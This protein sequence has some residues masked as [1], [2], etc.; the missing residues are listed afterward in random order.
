[1]VSNYVGRCHL[2]KKIV[3]LPVATALLHSGLSQVHGFQF[4]NSRMA[5]RQRVHIFQARNHRV[6]QQTQREER[7][8]MLSS[9]FFY[10]LVVA[11]LWV[12]SSSALDS[13]DE[14]SFETIETR[15][16]S[17]DGS[18]APADTIMFDDGSSARLILKTDGNDS[19][20]LPPFG[21]GFISPA[22]AGAGNHTAS[23]TYFFGVLMLGGLNTSVA[24]QQVWL[25]NRDKPIRENGTLKFT[26]EGG[27]VLQD[28]DGTSVWSSGPSGKS[29]VGIAL[30][31][32]GNLQLYDANSTVFWQSFDEPSDALLPGQL[33]YNE[34]RLVAGTSPNN[35]SSGGQYYVQM[36]SDGF[37]AFVRADAPLKYLNLGPG[38][39][40]R[41]LSTA[42]QMITN[43]KK[44]FVRKPY[45]KPCTYAN[46]CDRRRPDG[47]N[48]SHA[49]L[50]EPNNSSR[51][52]PPPTTYA[53][54]DGQYF[55]VTIGGTNAI[56]RI[57]PESAAT[58]S[59][60][61]LR[62][63]FD[64]HLRTYRWQKTNSSEEIYDLVTKQVDYCQHPD[65]C[66]DYGICNRGST[67]SC[68][69]ALINGS[70]YFRPS[71]GLGCSENVSL[72]CQSPLD[73][74]RLV[75]LGNLSYFS[76]IDNRAADPTFR[77]LDACKNACQDNCNCRAS[78]FKYDGNISDGDCYLLYKILSIRANPLPGVG[79]YNS[80][81]FIKVQLPYLAPGAPPGNNN[82]S[83]SI[84]LNTLRKKNHQA[85]II[86]GS[87]ATGIVIIVIV[88]ALCLV[89]SKKIKKKK[90]DRD[91]GEEYFQHVLKMPKRFTYEELFAATE[92]FKDQLGAGGFGTVFKGELKDGTKIA[93]KRLD[94][95]GQG[96]KEFLAEV[97][98]IGNVNHFNLVR[99]IGFCVDKSF[100]L[101]VYE[102]MSNGSLD[103]WIF[104]SQKNM[105]INWQM[106]KKIILDIA[107]GLA[108]LHEECRQ[109]I[110]HFD[111]KPQNILLDDDFNAKVSDF[112][113]S[114]L[115]AR[116]QSQVHTTLKGTPG[117]LAPEWQQLKITL[118]VDVYSFGIVALEIICGRRNLDGSR[119]ETS[120][121]LL[122]LLQEKAE[123][124]HLIDIVHN[125]S[126]DIKLH[127]HD[128]LKMIKLAAWCLQDDHTRRP[129]MS[130]VVK[131]LE[132]AAEIEPNISYKFC[133]AMVHSLVNIIAVDSEPPQASVLS[134]PR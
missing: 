44:G 40:S 78:F 28:S 93:V 33:L 109:R 31:V 16:W 115:M 38:R 84:P 17:N 86:S 107:R 62:L 133:H 61:Y 46:G 126:M 79:P 131:V 82:V 110:V 87:V 53:V 52:R 10:L 83:A 32:N 120:K 104:H 103:K 23:A 3:R 27:L 34:A 9:P 57:S 43:P 125:S 56:Y 30:E 2:A 96:M 19:A 91:E 74:H 49:N 94:N 35:W 13:Y 88:V 73:R 105:D 123:A 80:S 4:Q 67:C 121:H 77:S 45:T 20:P 64:G 95:R 22:Q 124:N 41:Q 118:K 21:C 48:P 63:G 112:G 122:R 90:K 76:F 26:A 102:Y 47:T 42:K 7:Q 97:E 128:V 85:G 29:L 58:V 12:S 100:Q 92:N 68:P 15:T 106:R 99:L 89:I 98:T 117:Y 116:D 119:S 54:H 18:I 5:R 134:A 108:Y 127:E 101:L 72:S 51:D 1:M 129:Q 71:T 39:T 66:G 114:K 37:S 50:F 59:Y 130:M 75:N 132:G 6:P 11:P 36:G 8:V 69:K 81:A 60:Q 25:A 55:N 111:I 14:P 24:H 113:L 70:T 65:V